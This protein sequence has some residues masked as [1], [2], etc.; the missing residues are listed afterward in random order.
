MVIV[1]KVFKFSTPRLFVV[2][3]SCYCIDEG[4]DTHSRWQDIMKHHA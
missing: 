3:T 1:S 4:V 2:E